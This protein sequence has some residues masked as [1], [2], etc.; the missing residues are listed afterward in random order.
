ML[1]TPRPL[2]QNVRCM[3]NNKLLEKLASLKPRQW[4]F[5]AFGLWVESITLPQIYNYM[6]FDITPTFTGRI[7]A[8]GHDA[9]IMNMLFSLL[10]L[11]AI[12]GGIK[13]YE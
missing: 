2:T 5:L 6:V 8:S 7:N 3:K 9:L 1:R 10:G 4:L 12:I 11:I 13:N